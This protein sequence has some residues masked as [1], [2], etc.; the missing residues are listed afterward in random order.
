[1]SQRRHSDNRSRWPTQLCRSRSCGIRR[2]CGNFAVSRGAARC[3]WPA[4]L[5][6]GF[7][8]HWW[9]RERVCWLP[10]E[11]HLIARTPLV[12]VQIKMKEHMDNAL[13]GCCASCVHSLSP[14]TQIRNRSKP[15]T[16]DSVSFLRMDGKHEHKRI[17]E[18]SMPSGL[19]VLWQC[20]HTQFYLPLVLEWCTHNN[21]VANLFRCLCCT[22]AVIPLSYAAQIPTTQD[23]DMANVRLSVS[24]VEQ[25]VGTTV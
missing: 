20:V 22:Q 14:N 17:N 21:S 13:N 19:H 2:C 8:A 11:L 12:I 7:R 15:S 25:Q 6:V 9:D 16:L 3:G 10:M 23:P 1:M 4:P 5:P 18:G 24:R